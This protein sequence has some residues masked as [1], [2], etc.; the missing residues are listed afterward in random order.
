M[1][2]RF[3]TNFSFRRFDLFVGP[4]LY[5][6]APE[7]P[8]LFKKPLL[9]RVGLLETSLRILYGADDRHESISKLGVRPEMPTE[10]RH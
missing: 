7:K 5:R 4:P 1:H 8:H 10:P 3:S 2:T 9:G 6:L